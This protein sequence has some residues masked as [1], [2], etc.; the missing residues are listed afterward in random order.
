MALAATPRG[1]GRGVKGQ[2][3]CQVLALENRSLR[4]SCCRQTDPGKYVY[5]KT[6]GLTDGELGA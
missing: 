5:A 1:G 3:N 4:A 2:H 6:T